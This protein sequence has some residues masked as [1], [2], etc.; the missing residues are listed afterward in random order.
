MHGHLNLKHILQFYFSCT[1]ALEIGIY[2]RHKSQFT[3]GY[4]MRLLIM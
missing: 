1:V 2:P 4:S 3:V